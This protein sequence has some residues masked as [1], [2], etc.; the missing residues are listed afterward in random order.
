MNQGNER[1]NGWM[2]DE[3]NVFLQLL[4]E[5]R[6][7]PTTWRCTCGYSVLFMCKT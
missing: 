3:L 5:I 4:K 6:Y 1:M 7:Q 2:D